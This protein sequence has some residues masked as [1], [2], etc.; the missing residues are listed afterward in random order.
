MCEG[1]DFWISDSE[2]EMQVRPVAEKSD[3]SQLLNGQ[4]FLFDHDISTFLLHD[5]EVN[6][7]YRRRQLDTEGVLW[8]V[9]VNDG[10]SVGCLYLP[11]PLLEEVLGPR[12]G[13]Q[14]VLLVV[15]GCLCVP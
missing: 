3:C 9:T 11:D 15:N 5:L 13:T 8:I 2:H 4:L 6:I 7:L 14:L 10:R 1:P 12:N